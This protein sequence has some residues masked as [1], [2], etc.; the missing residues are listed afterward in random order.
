MMQLGTCRRFVRVR[1][2]LP[3][4]AGGFLTLKWWTFRRRR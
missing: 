2:W 3:P 1:L 4:D